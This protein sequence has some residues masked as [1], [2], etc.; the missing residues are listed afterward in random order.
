MCL[1]G[2]AFEVPQG[3]REPKGGFRTSNSHR[4]SLV[5]MSFPRIE[6]RT[7]IFFRSFRAG[8]ISVDGGILGPGDG[9][10]LGARH[11]VIGVLV[12]PFLETANWPRA[13]LWISAVLS[14][15]GFSSAVKPKPHGNLERD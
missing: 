13:S 14:V 4:N 9:P 10:R 5:P 2:I 3:E 1:Y 7:P 8:W 12:A 6:L 11:A 15:I